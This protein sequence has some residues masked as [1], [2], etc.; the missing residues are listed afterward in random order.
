MAIN[1]KIIR[2]IGDLFGSYDAGTEPAQK[3][4]LSCYRAD[5]P[6]TFE[7]RF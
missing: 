4:P 6:D 7:S 3:P 1:K 2:E 5:D